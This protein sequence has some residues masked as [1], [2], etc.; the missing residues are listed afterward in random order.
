[1]GL[2]G[3]GNAARYYKA[4]ISLRDQPYPFWISSWS[5]GAFTGTNQGWAS[6]LRAAGNAA[7]G[8]YMDS[9][10]SG[11]TDYFVMNNAGTFNQIV[12]LA[13]AAPNVWHHY[14][15]YSTATAHS[16]YLDGISFDSLRG[17]LPPRPTPA[18]QAEVDPFSISNTLSGA[19]TFDTLMVG[20]L[21]LANICPTS[22]MYA[23]VVFGSGI[24]TQQQITLLASGQNPLTIAGL[25]IL[26]YFPLRGD[27]SDFGPRRIGL[28]QSAAFAPVWGDHPPVQ[29]HQRR[30]RI[31]LRASG[32]VVPPP[33][34][35]P[36]ITVFA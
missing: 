24:I 25:G 33:A 10:G 21:G 7:A 32:V 2:Y 28:Q 30:R 1:M 35:R 16:F 9:A 3:T 18:E 29:P 4:P 15:G 26:A 31:P 20:S 19:M 5:Y 14:I 34:A 8:T 36:R 23:E 27:L 6:Y 17:Q 12:H 13:G 11:Q 22:R